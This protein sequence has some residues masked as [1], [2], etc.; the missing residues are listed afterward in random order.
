VAGSLLYYNSSRSVSGSKKPG[1]S[2]IVLQVSGKEQLSPCQVL[3]GQPANCAFG[4][5][6]EISVNC[7]A[8]AIYWKVLMYFQ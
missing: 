8:A 5:E 7:A 1:A 4:K 2:H 6:Y 3:I